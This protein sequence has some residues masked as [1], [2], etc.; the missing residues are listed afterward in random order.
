MSF[1]RP[2]VLLLAWLPL[3]WAAWEWRGSGRRGALM[4]KAVAVLAVLLALAQPRL[5]VH[6]TKVALGILVDTSSSLPARD[7]ETAST[8]AT[9]VERGRGRHW[10]AVYPFA[11]SPRAPLEE[12]RGKTGWKFAETRGTAGRGTN[13]EAAIRDAE[14][15]LPAGY[16]PRLLLVSD[17]N[18]NSGSVSRAIWQ[19]QQL[20]VP[21]DTMP[22]PGRPQPNLL[23][24]SVTIPSQVFSGERFPID[25]AVTSPKSSEAA[26]EITAEG[27]SLGSDKVKLVAGVNRFRLHANVNAAGA[28]ELVGSIRSAELGEAGFR[29]SVTLRRP[30][31][32]LLSK[33]PAGTETHLMR[34][35]EAN[36]FEVQRSA[37]GVPDKLHD[38]QLVI[39]NNWDARTIPPARKTAVEEFVKQ[40]GGVLWIA[41]EQN[42]YVEKKE[43]DEDALDRALPAKLAP[44]RTPE[45]TCV[46]LIVDKSSSMEGKKIEL[47][48]LAAVGVV[49]NLRPIDS[50][51]VLIFDNSF[52]WAVPIRRAEDKALIKRLISGIMPD[53]GTQIAPALTEAYRRI[54]PQKGVYKHIV[55]LTDGISEEGDSMSLAREASANR[56]T[57][58]TVGLGQDVNRAF[59][60]KV[61]SFSQGKAYLLTDPS[62]LEQILLRDVQEHTGSTAVEKMIK[63][64]V[65]KQAEIL[66]GVGIESAPALRG[67]VRFIARP[68]ADTI[69]E[70]DR[71]DPLLVRWQFGLGRAA[72]FTSDAK[73]RWA[74][75][76]VNWPGFDRLWTNIFRDLL[77]HAAASEATAEFDPA[78]NELVVDYRLARNVAEPAKAPDLFAFG[79]DGFQQ[80]V[81]IT[82]MAA[83]LFRARVPLGA[84]QGLFRIRP[85]VESRAFPEIGFYRQEDEL[86]DY[87]SN[88]L[89]LKQVASATGGRFNPPADKIFDS[90]GRSIQTTMEL[91]PGLLAFA[92]ILTLAELILR[93]WKGIAEGLRW[94]RPAEAA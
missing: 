34:T 4:V 73:S 6:S 46:V 79:P 44:P 51:G 47:A 54:L 40:G 56:V 12:E 78:N 89:L 76:W 23:V 7:L 30:R 24:Q 86:R 80:P 58:S 59:L 17:G 50:V 32:L 2:W 87:G 74:T 93:K 10:A 25:V 65:V 55:L 19:A 35:L 49:E 38:Y 45:G 42:I 84:Q 22:M 60:E 52:Q 61:A 16:L 33:D 29:N 8:L 27:R 77:P 14:A 36:Q 75:N 90:G 83:G 48:R 41:G 39:F 94:R 53:G 11:R 64:A 88:E 72:V 9:R 37:S 1:D 71:K 67:Y 57:I 66:E 5:T 15:S 85:L 63:P 3:A 26:V 21:I 81:K 70:A 91:W 82:K 31:V 92:I 20:G 43:Q 18:E 68:T 13:I 28:I 62:G 69:L